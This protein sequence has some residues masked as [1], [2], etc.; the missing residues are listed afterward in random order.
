MA[1]VDTDPDTGLI[2]NPGDDGSKMF[3]C[4]TDIRALAGSI[5]NHS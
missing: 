1:S 4:I 2:L 5:L 3:E